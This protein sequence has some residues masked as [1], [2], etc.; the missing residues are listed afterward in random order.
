MYQV[1]TLSKICAVFAHTSIIWH[2]TEHI[3]T[4]YIFSYWIDYGYKYLRYNIRYL[5][6]YPL[7]CMYVCM[8]VCSSVGMGY[9]IPEALL[10]A[11]TAQYDQ[12]AFTLTGSFPLRSLLSAIW[13]TLLCLLLPLLHPPPTEINRSLT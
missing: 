3:E 10:R 2:T 8:Y 9:G 4:Y 6:T 13:R 12:V 5:P 7:I 11:L 1:S